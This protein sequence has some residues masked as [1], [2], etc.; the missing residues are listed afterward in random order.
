MNPSAAVTN[1]DTSAPVHTRT[2]THAKEAI[3][4]SDCLQYLLPK[5]NFIFKADRI[6]REQTLLQI[7]TFF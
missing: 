2:Q 7:C 1:L 3:T 4:P 6:P 5:L